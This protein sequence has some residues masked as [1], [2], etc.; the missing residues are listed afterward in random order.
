MKNKFLFIIILFL[1]S[2]SSKSSYSV[3]GNISLKNDI[4]QLNQNEGNSDIQLIIHVPLYKMVFEKRDNKFISNI[5]VDILIIN[6]NN[7]LI[8]SNSWDE[9][10][11]KNYYEETRESSFHILKHKFQLPTGF[12]K[13]NFIS[14]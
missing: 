10:I 11:I 4:I 7:K 13:I 12:Y 9:E 5:T 1:L 8:Y 6:E 14:I 2:C 3:D